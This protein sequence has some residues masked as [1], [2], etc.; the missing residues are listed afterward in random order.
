VRGVAGYGSVL[1]YV[2]VCCREMCVCESIKK[3]GNISYP[4][5]WSV[6]F[7]T[8]KSCPLCCSMLQ[9]VAGS[10]RELQCVAVTRKGVCS[11]EFK[12]I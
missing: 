9:G 10:C 1:Q 7:E 6:L 5:E 8:V 3:G 4:L 12:I 11:S 2:A